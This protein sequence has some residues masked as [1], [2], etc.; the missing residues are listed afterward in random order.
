MRIKLASC[1]QTHSRW[2]NEHKEKTKMASARKREGCVFRFF[3][4][5]SRFQRSAF[6]GAAFTGSMWTIGQNDAKHV[7]LH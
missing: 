4:P 5:V 1:I 3:H 2:R 6:S 7:H